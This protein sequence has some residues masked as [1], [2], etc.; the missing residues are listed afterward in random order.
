ML[1]LVILMPELEWPEV[2]QLLGLEQR[3]PF[4]RVK[5]ESERKAL[6]A[7][8][9]EKAPREKQMLGAAEWRV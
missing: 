1:I 6:E 5:G 9:G 8:G 4:M 3:K 7:M 2:T